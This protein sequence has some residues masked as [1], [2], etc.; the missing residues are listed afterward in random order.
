MEKPN[1]MKSSFQNLIESYDS[2]T[3]E[4]LSQNEIEILPNL[5]KYSLLRFYA[6]RSIRRGIEDRDYLQVLKNNLKD[7]GDKND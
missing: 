1:Y 5:L 7:I 6:V 4:P 3:N 2:T